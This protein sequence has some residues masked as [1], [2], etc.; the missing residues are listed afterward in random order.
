MTLWARRGSIGAGLI[1]LAIGVPANAWGDDDA[2]QA[3]PAESKQMKR[4]GIATA[5]AIVP[6]L[7]VHGSGHF[8]AGDSRTGSRLLLL[9]GAGLGGVFVGFTP[10][11]LTGASRRFVGPL[12]ALTAMGAG[13]FVISA[14]ADIYGVVAP[15]GGVGAPSLVAPQLQAELG[16][17]YVYDP[18]F[19]YRHFAFYA[20]DAR[21]A[22]WRFHPSAWFSVDGIAS[23]LR[24]PLA[25]R[26]LGPRPE[27][28]VVSDG[29]YVEVEVAL[30]RHA[31]VADHFITT[32]GE[33]S[34]GGRLDMRRFA[35]SLAGSFAELGVG[36]AVQRYAY[37]VKGAAADVGELLLARFGYGMYVGWPKGPH[38]EVMLYYDHR[39]DDFA[40]G[41]KL[42]GIPSGPAGHFGIEGRFYL[43]KHW[44][45]AGEA[46]AGSAYVTGLSVLF[47][48]GREE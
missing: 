20:L 18:V 47:R 29:S 35:D 22:A 31:D 28:S 45:L 48:Q 32:T 9:E 40:A 23:R 17:R 42:P 8:V 26:L 14:V 41:L 11:V 6:G 24:G 2:K 30:T 15:P 44:G 21:R 33:A 19:S 27:P 5:A 25:F 4:R 10:I 37:E 43:S 13:I 16:Y 38:G 34:I 46:V 7:A 36:W 12:I 39:H 1:A 3:T